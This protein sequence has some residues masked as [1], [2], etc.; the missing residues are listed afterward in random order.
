MWGKC[1]FH[2]L[3]YLANG[4]E[5]TLS[6]LMYGQLVS[7]KKVSFPKH[8]SKTISLSEQECV[9]IWIQSQKGA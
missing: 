6:L 2:E 8:E 9:L 1:G 5:L 3:V 7:I 4:I